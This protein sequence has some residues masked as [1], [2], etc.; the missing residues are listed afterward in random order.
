M[1]ATAGLSDPRNSEAPAGAGASIAKLAGRSPQGTSK[2]S[3]LRLTLSE[4]CDR[5]HWT[6]PPT[7]VH[8][9]HWVI[10]MVVEVEPETSGV[11][12]TLIVQL[13]FAGTCIA[14]VAMQVPV[15]ASV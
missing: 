11:K 1:V 9:R 14:Y 12:V 7:T 5:S 3:P 10:V 6:A 13:L 4:T 15:P 8:F 2:A